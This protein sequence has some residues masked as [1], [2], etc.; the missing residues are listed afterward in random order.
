MIPGTFALCSQF[1]PLAGGSDLE[2][3][4]HEQQVHVQ[5]YEKGVY[6]LTLVITMPNCNCMYQG[7]R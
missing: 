2:D 1:L 4:H 6:F 5:N 7:P 3:S